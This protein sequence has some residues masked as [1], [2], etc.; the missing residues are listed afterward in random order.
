MKGFASV[1]TTVLFLGFTTLVRVAALATS[2]GSPVERV[3]TLLEDLQSKI[4]EDGKAEQRIFDKYACWCDKTSKRKA[5]DISDAR[6]ELKELGLNILE[7]K[8]TV[9]TLNAEIAKLAA[10]IKG[11]ED[12]QAEATSLR[13]KE[14]SEFQSESAEAKQALAA[15]EKAIV[16]L[17]KA[18]SPSLLQ[19]QAAS[20][21]AAVNAVIAVLPTGRSLK[22]AQ[23]ALLSEFTSAKDTSSYTPQSMTIQGLLQDMYATFSSDLESSMLMESTQNREFEAFIATKTEQLKEMKAEK[24]KKEGDKAAAETQLADTTQTYD[25]TDAQMKADIGFFDETKA[26]C[27]DKH[28]E[29]TLRDSLRD[30]EVEG[31]KKALEILTSDDARDLFAST[32]KAGKETHVDESIDAGVS[33]MQLRQAQFVSSPAASHAYAALQA[34]ARRVH[35]VRLAAIAMSVKTSKVGHFDEVITAIEKMIAALREEDAADI[36]KRNQCKNEYQKINSTVAETEW[37]IE[38]NE[39]KIDKLIKLIELRKKELTKTN[40]GL[41]EVAQQIDDMDTQR[42]ADHDDFEKSKA[43][44][45]KAV[46]LL[47]AARDALIAYYSKNSVAMGPV[48]GEVKGIALISAEPAFN[49]SADQAPDADFS[50]KGSHK[51]EA[52]GVVSIM[53]MIIEDLTDE[54]KKGIEEEEATQKA[55]EKQRKSA[56]E[57]QEE[58]EAKKANL[59]EQIADRS[60]EKEHEES[61]KQ[62][63]QG[64]LKDELDYK[65]SIKPDCDWILGAFEKRA[66]KRAAELQGLGGAKDF[67]AGASPPSFVQVRRNPMFLG[68]RN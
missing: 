32:I 41:A 51:G 55:F 50:S 52:K 68:I 22:P 16:V 64:D 3:V 15:L 24:Q 9:A 8:G 13:E 25:D 31:I 36:A 58:L 6:A 28:A 40:D 21:K 63:N 49:V 2:S 57:L 53:T 10:D 61:T 7:L 62:E 34:Q 35:S 29:W 54:I 37:L 1:L 48:Q 60:E 11:N 38:K 44:D 46:E 47:V 30:E 66:A 17:G 19:Q 27:E 43:D 12:E 42:K 45:Q 20:A 65:A 5:T 26:V 18:T 59:K 23:E 39:A 14:N 67:L 56:V 4:E 33:F